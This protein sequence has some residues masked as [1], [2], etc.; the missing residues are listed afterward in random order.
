MRVLLVKTSSIGDVIHALPAVTDAARAHPGLKVDWV[1][2]EALAPIPSWH[3]AVDRVIPAAVRRWR[4]TPLKAL[5]SGEP[6]AFRRHLRAARYDAVVDAQGLYKSAVLARLANGPRH[7]L[8]RR[9]AREPMASWLMRHRHAVPTGQHAILRVRQLMAAALGYEVA[10]DSLPDY[11]LDRTGFAPPALL[12]QPYTVLIHGTAWPT[13]RWSV[14]RWRAAAAAAIA[15]GH[16]VA[17]PFAAKEDATRAHAIA[18]GLE[19]AHPVFTPGLDDAA[20]VIANAVAAIAVD[21]GLAHLAAAFGV[22]TLT[23]YGATDPAL[24]GTLGAAQATW[25]STLAC[26]PCRRR[27]CRVAP[28]PL[29]PPPCLEE[30]DGPAAWAEAM[31]LVPAAGGTP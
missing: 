29:A 24:T 4:R 14:A 30:L 2:E 31:A 19:G 27:S 25:S 18:E 5:L 23:L 16:A 8:D 26:A 10:A 6:S 17:L 20:A 3:P 11:G 22:P 9:S 12:P 1:V 7:G 28:D 15:G 13:K 21:T